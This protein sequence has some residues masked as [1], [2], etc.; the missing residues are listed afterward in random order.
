[1]GG[2]KLETLSQT[3]KYVI[4]NLVPTGSWLAIITFNDEA[5]VVKDLTEIKSQYVRDELKAVIPAKVSGG[6]CI[7]CG[8]EEA[9]RIL[10]IKLSDVSNGEIFVIS[11]GKDNV[12]SIHNSKQ[13]AVSENII[14]HTISVTQDADILLANISKETGGMHF[15]YLETGSISFIALF[16]ELITLDVTSDSRHSAVLASERITTTPSNIVRFSFSIENG[17]GKDTF[18]TV[19]LQ[20][21]YS[22]R[23]Q[24]RISGPNNYNEALNTTEKT[25]TIMIPGIAQAGD[26]EM[27]VTMEKSE[28]SVEYL[29]KSTPTNYD[30]LKIS[31]TPSATNINFSSGEIPII[32]AEVTKGS[33]SVL[34]VNVTARVEIGNGSRVCDISLYDKGMDPDGIDN[35]GIYSGYIFPHCLYEGRINIKVYASGRKGETIIMRGTSGSQT[36]YQDD[37]P[38]VYEDAFQRVTVLEDLYIENYVDPDQND[39]VPPGRITDVNIHHIVKQ[40]IPSGESRNF[41]ISW[42][43]TGDDKNVGQASAY[44]LRISE[45][46]ETLLN[47][48]D[49]AELLDMKNISLSPQKSGRMEALKIVVD[50]EQSYTGTTFFALKAVDEAGNVGEVSN[51]LSIVVAKGYRAVG[52]RGSFDDDVEAIDKDNMNIYVIIGASGGGFIL[53]LMIFT[54]LLCRKRQVKKADDTNFHMGRI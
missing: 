22:S 19:L 35:D 11:D 45:D 10:K 3:A 32:F 13:K 51:I 39:I 20:S 2:S 25:A 5:Y 48:F 43:A 44:I 37:E 41:T 54:I 14:V 49:S 18:V 1:M 31:A 29:V 38:E 26:Y 52:E 34:N 36:P 30:I 50:A 12:G 8:I 9:I 21:P 46:F 28:Q 40:K 33:S 6:T 15:T 53:L 47:D 24:L 7:G 27:T 4:Q 23:M 42:T 16:G 17:L